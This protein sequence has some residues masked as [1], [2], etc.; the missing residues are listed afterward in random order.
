[1]VASGE[2]SAARA[3]LSRDCAP[4]DRSSTTK[5]GGSTPASRCTT[6]RRSSSCCCEGD[7]EGSLARRGAWAEK[8][9]GVLPS[10]VDQLVLWQNLKGE[11]KKE[12][13]WSSEQNADDAAYAWYQY[14][15]YGGQDYSGKGGEFRARAVRRV[16]FNHSR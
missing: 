13:Y 6:T 8:Q 12:A 9:G 4:G 16:P 3:R 1:M 7:F 15:S 5:L 2:R 14:F 11:F 10:R